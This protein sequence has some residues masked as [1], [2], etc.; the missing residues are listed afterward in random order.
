MTMAHRESR[1]VYKFDSMRYWAENGMVTF[2]DERDGSYRRIGCQD[3]L[4]RAQS[5]GACSKRAEHPSEREK[6]I[7][8]A[9]EMEAC[10]S[11][12]HNQG[13]PLDPAFQAYSVRHKLYK[14]AMT[15]IEASAASP[16][17]QRPDPAKKPLNFRNLS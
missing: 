5:I 17:I 7:R 10:A 1:K 13:D 8:V 3:F 6:F 4:E 16:I 12:A 2:V 14:Q 15:L 11:E 9:N